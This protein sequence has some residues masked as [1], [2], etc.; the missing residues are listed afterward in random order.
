MHEFLDGNLIGIEKNLKIITIFPNNKTMY[1]YGN[2]DSNHEKC[3]GMLAN[4]CFLENQLVL[5]YI[6]DRRIETFEDYL[7]K[8]DHVVLLN[9]SEIGLTNE[10]VVFYQDSITNEQIDLLFEILEK[11][12]FEYIKICIHNKDNRYGPYYYDEYYETPK[13]LKKEKY[14]LV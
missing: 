5:S 11:S 6:K 2:H 12:N 4:E 8:S 14:L 1:L 13:T 7:V 10:L 9:L 3:F